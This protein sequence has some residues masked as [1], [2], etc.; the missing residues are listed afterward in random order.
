MNIELPYTLAECDCEFLELFGK[1]EARVVLVDVRDDRDGQIRQRVRDEMV[2][3]H[4]KVLQNLD[5]LDSVLSLHVDGSI[6]ILRHVLENFLEA[7][8][9]VVRDESRSDREVSE[10]LRGQVKFIGAT[11]AP[12]LFR[13]CYPYR[14]VQKARC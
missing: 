14:E 1:L 7:I 12:R 11:F 6:I 2:M 9:E 3:L 13:I 5:R 10:M 4:V 8:D